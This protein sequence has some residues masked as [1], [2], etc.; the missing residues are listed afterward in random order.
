MVFRYLELLR[1]EGGV[2]RELWGEMASL[3]EMR[4]HYR[5]ARAVRAGGGAVRPPSPPPPPSHTHLTPH[6]L[7][8]PPLPMRTGTG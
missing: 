3:A 2:S 1:G 5:R 7:A 6:P 4:F 8:Y